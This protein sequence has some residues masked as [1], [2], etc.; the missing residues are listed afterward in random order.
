MPAGWY[1]RNYLPHFDGGAIYQFITFHLADSLP[2]QVLQRWSIELQGLEK[3]QADIETRKRIQAYVDQGHGESFLARQDVGALV[4]N[5]LL[6]FDGQRYSLH[7]WVVMPNHVHVLVGLLE[8]F[9]LADIVMSWKS[10][11]AKE[12]NK[13]LGRKGTL[14]QREY[15]DRF[16]RNADHFWRSVQYI[17][18]NPIKAGLCAKAEGWSFSSARSRTGHERSLVAGVTRS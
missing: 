1:S 14:W 16:I 12:I 9:A 8:G 6:Y 17:E 5:A 18:E 7:A 10:Y 3:R 4:Q 2:Q 13:I 15:F 11:T